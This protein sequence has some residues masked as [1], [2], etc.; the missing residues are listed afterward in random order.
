MRGIFEDKIEANADTSGNQVVIR[1]T[2]DGKTTGMY[3]SPRKAR[4]LARKINCVASEIEIA[5]LGRVA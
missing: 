1:F 2:I 3:L 4:K 5:E